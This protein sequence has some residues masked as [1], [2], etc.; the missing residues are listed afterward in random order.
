MTLS[1]IVRRCLVSL[2][3]GLGCLAASSAG[4][5]V[6]LNI[7]S[8]ILLG[9]SG[10]TVGALPGTY[11]VS[12]SDGNC[13]AVFGACDAAHFAFTNEGD[14][15]AASNALLDSVFTDSGLGLFDAQPTLTAGCTLSNSGCEVYTPYDLGGVGLLINFA[16][17]QPASGPFGNDGAFSI[18]SG[19]ESIDGV[20]SFTTWAVWVADPP[21]PVP[22]PGSLALLGLAGMALLWT[23]RRHRQACVA[24][25]P[26]G[27]ALHQHCQRDP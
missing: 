11:S 21:T 3:I 8:G 15:A 10:I 18:Q 4:A 6:I 16:L 24:R 5:A 23:Q 25:N 20:D 1:R 26:R 14:A 19:S 13:A 7:S 27:P 12:F 9:A 17:N 2:S 22:E